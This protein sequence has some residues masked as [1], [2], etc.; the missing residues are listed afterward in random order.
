MSI[1]TRLVTSILALI[2]LVTSATIESSYGQ[3]NRYWV[4]LNSNEAVITEGKGFVGFKFSDDFK[5]LIYTVNVHDIDNVT[6]VNVYLKND[7]RADQPV[8]DLLKKYRESNREKDR[9]T[10]VTKEG[11]ITGTINLSG[12]TKEELTGP[13]DGKSM[14]SLHELMID[15]MLYIIVFTK[16]YP[17]GEL[18]GDSFVGMDDVF[19]DA[20]EFNW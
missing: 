18:K 20:D 9:W 3:V 10:D 5:E 8:L 1:H 15:N 7:T 13:L 19:H 17:H 11:Q 4:A 16:D 6:A 12:V 2:T 14:Q